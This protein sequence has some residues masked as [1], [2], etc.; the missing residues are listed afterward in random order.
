MALTKHDKGAEAIR[1]GEVRNWGG[2]T[3]GS[4]RLRSG[5]ALTG[6]ADRFGMT[7]ELV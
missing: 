7:S 3:A 5:Q 2:R 4:L 6:L 1:F